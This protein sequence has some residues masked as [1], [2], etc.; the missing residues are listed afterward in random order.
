MIPSVLH[1]VKAGVAQRGWPH[2]VDA[3]KPAFIQEEK[4]G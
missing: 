1:E 3:L 4:T 2:G